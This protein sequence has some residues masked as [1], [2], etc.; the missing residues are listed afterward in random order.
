MQQQPS[1]LTPVAVFDYDGTCINGQSGKLITTWLFK[2][3]YLSIRGM[4]SL[5]MWGA[6]YALHIP[7]REERARE[8]IFRDLNIYSAKEVEGIMTAFHRE[9]LVPRYRSRAMGEVARRKAEGC[10]TLLVS[11]TF[12]AIAHDAAAYLGADG[13]VATEMERDEQGYYTGRVLGDVVEGEAK[14]AAAQA[15]ANEK[16]GKDKWYLA[17]A[18]GDHHSDI[19]LLGSATHPIAISPDLTLRRIARKNGWAMSDWEAR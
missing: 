7:H 16:L 12:G 2:N 10:V 8:V 18:Y 4:S 13:F 15:W 1:Q 19:E 3:G 17:Y 14:V 5:A 9:V 6:R 11:A